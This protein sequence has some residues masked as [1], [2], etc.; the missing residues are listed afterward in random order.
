MER[1]QHIVC[2]ERLAVAPLDVIANVDGV[3]EVIWRH[4]PVASQDTD[5]VLL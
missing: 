3:R 4:C 5:D 1:E 2:S